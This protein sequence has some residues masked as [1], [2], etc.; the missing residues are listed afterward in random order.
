MEPRSL[1]LIFVLA[2]AFSLASCDR[3]PEEADAKVEF[4]RLYPAAEIVS[5]RMSED[6]VVARSFDITYRRAGKTETRT[7][8]FQYM[9]NDKGVYAR[10]AP[11]LTLP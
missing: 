2:L 1:A 6:E 8:N 4:L 10:P 3:R 11:S 5:I 7:L 9:K